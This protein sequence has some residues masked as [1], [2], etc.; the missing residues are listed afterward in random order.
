MYNRFLQIIVEQKEE[1]DILLGSEI[2]AREAEKQIDK[3]SR[4]VQLIS[5]IRRSGKSVL[6]HLLLRETNYAYV[7]FDDERLYDLSAKDY[8][9]LLETLYEVYGKF[10][11]LLLDEIQNIPQ[12]HLFVNRLH[13]RKIKIFVTGSNSKL[14]SH[15]MASHLTGRFLSVTILPFSFSEFL[16]ARGKDIGNMITAEE[17][18]HAKNLFGEYLTTGG[19]PEVVYGEAKRQYTE[20]L[21][22]SI[23]TRDIVYRYKIKHVRTFTEIAK[24]CLS[25]YAAEISYNR[26]KNI[27]GLGS[28]NT[29][30]NYI[31]Y[32]E[33]S[34]LIFCLSKFSYKKQENLRYR[35]IYLPDLSFVNDLADNFTKDTGKILE[36]IVFLGLARKYWHEKAELFYYKKSC[37]VDFVVVKNGMVIELIQVSQT[38]QAAKTRSREVNALITACEELKCR[39]MSI[40]TGDEAD[41][42]DHRGYKIIV[43]PVIPW[44]LGK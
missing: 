38:L 9:I 2:I 43:V 1:R 17:R 6:S 39:K 30:K 37:E 25:N 36:N 27:F 26:I 24:Y 41:I 20:T 23:I 21:I 44:L 33:S 42:I 3:S 32:I 22:D 13:R 18:G 12:W 34:Y 29:V 11:A 10:T 15:E 14:L 35:K 28:E 5:G 4:L 19:F 16:F 31:S 7:N 40:I 8:N